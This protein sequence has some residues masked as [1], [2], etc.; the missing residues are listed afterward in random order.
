MSDNLYQIKQFDP[1]VEWKDSG[2][3]KP[4]KLTNT[5]ISGL[6]IS[7]PVSENLLF[8]KVF[9]CTDS[10]STAGMYID[11]EWQFR[12]R[13]EDVMKIPHFIRLNI[14]SDGIYLI[15][16]PGYYVPQSTTN[17]GGQEVFTITNSGTAWHYPAWQIAIRCDEI[18]YW[19][20]TA[21]Y[22]PAG[23]NATYNVA[24]ACLSQG[25]V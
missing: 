17:Y 12:L 23:G 25:I 20:N 11:A 15:R 24:L 4:I 7:L 18:V 16:I 8:R 14:N 6:Q 3:V 5:A 2:G 22:Y 10:A 1:S 19:I 13:G 9:F 21:K